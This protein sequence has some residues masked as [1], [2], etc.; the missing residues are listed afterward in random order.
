M[1]IREYKSTAWRADEEVRAINNL[2]AYHP[3]QPNRTSAVGPI[4]GS[5][6]I[7]GNK[8]AGRIYHT[9]THNNFSLFL[10]RVNS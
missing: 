7:N 2:V 9:Q 5:L 10:N 8:A 1:E 3:N 4:V 6:K